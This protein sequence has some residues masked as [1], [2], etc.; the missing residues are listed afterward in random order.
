MCTDNTLKKK[1]NR[2]MIFLI[3]IVLTVAGL[4]V[5]AFTKRLSVTVI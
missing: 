4:I 3:I 2:I 1:I 5:N